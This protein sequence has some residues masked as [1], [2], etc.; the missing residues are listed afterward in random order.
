MAA[1]TATFEVVGARAAEAQAAMSAYFAELDELFP[2]GFDP[3]DALIG[4]AASFDPPGGRFVVVRDHGETIGCGGV[5]SIDT[6]TGEIKRMWIA[7]DRRGRGLAPQLLAFL[8]QLSREIG[9]HTV[10]LDTNA[11]LTTAITMYERA[12]YLADRKSVV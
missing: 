12:G 3:G 11:T 5:Q 10:R 2:T 9:H 4:E 7:P 1:V 6:T 8:E